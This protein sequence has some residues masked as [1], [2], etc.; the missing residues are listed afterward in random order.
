[1]PGDNEVDA[2]KGQL[3]P[4]TPPKFHWGQ[5]NL[6]EQFKSFKRVAEF[7]F[8]GQYEKCS[9]NVKCCSILNWLDIE[10]YSVYDNLP[11]SEA[12]N[13]SI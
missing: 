7:T 13:G 9:D 12:Q 10:A 4:F 11:I 3:P 6:N 2:H 1:M 5:D 8:K